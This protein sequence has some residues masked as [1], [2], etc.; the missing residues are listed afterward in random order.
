MERW[1]QYNIANKDIML[2][3]AKQ[4]QKLNKEKVNAKNRKCRRNNR[5]K[6]NQYSNKW[7]NNNLERVKA[8]QLF[9]AAKTRAKNKNIHFN[10]T[11]DWIF[12]KL[13]IGLCEYSGMKFSFDKTGEPKLMSPSI[14]RINP[15]LG[16]TESNCRIVLYPLNLFK[17]RYNLTD[18]IIIAKE[19]VKYQTI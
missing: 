9:N 1:K 7:A 15:S 14:D 5:E 19:F 12:E 3:K 13:K 6:Y 16:Y 2:E 18:L 4:Y 17:N 10:I 8:R 11:I